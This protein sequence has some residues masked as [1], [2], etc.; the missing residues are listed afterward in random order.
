MST[1]ELSGIKGITSFTTYDNGELNECKLNDYNLIHTKYGDFVPQYGD[2]GIRRKQLKALSFYKNGKVKS[3][4]LE[5]QTEVNTSIGTFPAELVTFFE[6]GSL[7]S[8]FPLNG[9]ISGFWSEE[10]EGALAQKYDFTFPFGSFNVKIIGLRFY[11]GGKVRSLILWPT[12]TIT[13][14]TPAG[15]IPIRTGFKLFEDGSIESVEPAKPVPVETPIGSINVYDAN[16][17]GIDADKNSLGFDRNGRLTSLATFDII[18]VK[19]S[20][21]ERK[22]IFPK[23]KPGLMEDYEKVPVKLFFGEDSVTIDDGMRATEY[24]ISECIFKITGGDYTETTTCGDCSKC[25]GCM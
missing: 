8:L 24:S 19:K 17:L 6:D 23:L 11:P 12:E 21:G 22:I 9:Q 18:S 3:I 15:K 4:S 20:N 13:I 10:D 16:A 25:K 1:V 14:N 5:Q 7:N 2:P